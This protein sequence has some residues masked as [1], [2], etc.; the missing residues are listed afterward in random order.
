MMH[1]ETRRKL[2]ELNLEELI[3]YLDVHMLDSQS[4]PLSFEERF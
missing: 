1:D 3:E 2:R 4:L